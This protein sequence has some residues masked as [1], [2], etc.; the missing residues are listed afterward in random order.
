M[1]IVNEHEAVRLRQPVEADP[2]DGNPHKIPIIMPAGSEG[3]VV[4]VHGP[5]AKPLAY[6]VDG[7]GGSAL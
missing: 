1:T 6:E 7:T 2:I 4:H 3:V 5:A